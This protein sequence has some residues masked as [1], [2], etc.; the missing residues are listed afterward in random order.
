LKS[1]R[2]YFE[3]LDGD[4]DDKE[5]EMRSVDDRLRRTDERR[6]F[7]RRLSRLKKEEKKGKSGRRWGTLAI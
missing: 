2:R 3:K 5:A 1:Q 6:R 7:R 4:V